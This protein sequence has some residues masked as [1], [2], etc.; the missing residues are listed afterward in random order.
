[1]LRIRKFEEKVRDLFADGELHGNVHLY[2]GEEAVAVGACTAL[3]D[4]DIITST[5]RGHGHAIAK[6]LDV[7]LMMAELFGKKD[8]YCKGKAGSLHIADFDAG[9]LGANGIVGASVPIAAG[10]ALKSKIMGDNNVTVC[11]IGD[12]ATAQGAFHEGI[13][14]AATWDLPVVYVCENNLYGEMGH[15]KEQHNVKNVSS[16][17]EAYNVPGVT[18]DGMNV[19]EVHK[20]VK[21]AVDRARKGEGPSLIECL[22]YRYRGHFEGDPE[23]YRKKEEVLEWQKRDPIEKFKKQLIKD[24]KLDKD[25]FENI[26]N[27]IEEEIDDAVDFA[28]KSDYPDLQ[29]AYTDVFEKE[30][31]NE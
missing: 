1:M 13:N 17:A 18:I 15:F 7:K 5:H 10:S 3:K 19:V 21:P 12:G 31:L 30:T 26:V 8:G 27:E 6:G 9:M 11:F 24:G 2:I 16:M 28:R 4:G 22:T 29:E 14:I 20:N 25:D 23:L